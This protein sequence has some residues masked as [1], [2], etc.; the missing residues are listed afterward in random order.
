MI[1]KKP[2]A[3]DLR[4]NNTETSCEIA[5]APTVFTSLKC[6]DSSY[7][8]TWTATRTLNDDIARSQLLVEQLTFFYL[9][10]RNILKIE[11]TIVV[12]IRI[13]D[14]FG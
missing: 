4:I 10:F 12:E 1:K 3:D 2:W 6:N 8:L 14:H 13:P 11:G 5:K 7:G 9:Q